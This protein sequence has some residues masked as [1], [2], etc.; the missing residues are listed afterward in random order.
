MT[1]IDPATKLSMVDW[2]TGWFIDWLI[3]YVIE[4][5]IINKYIDWQIE[6]MTN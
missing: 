3:D 6:S 2:Q 4:Y 5:L 1:I